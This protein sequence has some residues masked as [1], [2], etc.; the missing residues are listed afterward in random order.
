MISE[1]SPDSLKSDGKEERFVRNFTIPSYGKQI[2][3]M[4][5]GF[6]ESML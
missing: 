6:K 4:T 1:R 5:E 3:M 2:F